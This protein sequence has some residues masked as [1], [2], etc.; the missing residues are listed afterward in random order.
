MT[1]PTIQFQNKIPNKIGF[2]YS[3]QKD[4]K[5]AHIIIVPV[6]YDGTSTWIKG[7]DKGP[8][9]ILEASQKLELY[10]IETNSEIYQKGIFTDQPVLEKSTPEKMATEVNKRISS[11]LKNNKFVIT[12]GGEHSISIGAIL[13]HQQKFG[14]ENITILHLDAHT[15][16][17]DE[18]YGSKYNHGCVMARIDKKSKIIQ[19]GIRSMGA[20]EKKNIKFDNVFFAQDI[21]NGKYGRNGKWI[22]HIIKKLT[23]KIYITF[24]LDV[25][26]P[27]IMSSTGTPEPGGILWYDVLNLLKQ[28]AQKN[29]I[30][31]FDI[32]ELCPNQINK[33]PDFMAALLIYKILTYKYIEYNKS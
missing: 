9:A 2:T 26:D 14:P 7:A 22:Q 18:Y 8:K 31:G 32:V 5:K 10:D 23:G 25:F 21:I 28:V 3:P 4:Y 19:V 30:I 17:R 13:A 6:P 12:L 29:E 15:D 11:H 1:A 24:D 33:S 27:S 20:E 16:Y